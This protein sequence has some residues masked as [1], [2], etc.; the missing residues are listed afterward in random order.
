[1]GENNNTLEEA[2]IFL[3]ELSEK[4]PK[5]PYEPELIPTLFAATQDSSTASLD[6]IAKLIERSQN[7]ATRVL[8]IANSAY[9]VLEFK[10]TSLARA[11]GVLGLREV[12]AMVLMVAMV[13]AIKGVKLPPG[14]DAH[15]LW[16]H[17]LQTATL[18]KALAQGIK[19]DAAPKVLAPENT[20]AMEPDEA[21]VAGLLHDL[22]KIFLASIR[23]EIWLAIEDLRKKENCGFAEAEIQYWGMDHGII[24]ARVLHTW[25]VPLLLTDAINWHH[26]PQL[27]PEGKLEAGLLAAANKLANADYKPGSEIPLEIM[28]LLP[29]DVDASRLADSIGSK[30]EKDDSSSLSGAVW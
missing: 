15:A 14:F 10:V 17:N 8:T 16:Q 18:A 13:S 9:Y 21:Y 5:V 28:A 12:R 24:A 7:L 30:L 23:P 11:I 22:G 20:L 19:G 3:N 4:P 25:K 26:A 2:R 29:K 6:S 1:M 27:A